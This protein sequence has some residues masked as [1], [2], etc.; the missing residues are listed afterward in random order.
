MTCKE[1]D[2]VFCTGNQAGGTYFVDLLQSSDKTFVVVKHY[3]DTAGVWI[4]SMP[5]ADYT[6]VKKMK[7]TSY[8]SRSAYDHAAVCP[9]LSTLC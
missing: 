8:S 7:K 5:H 4:L 9:Y 3:E 6:I 2:C 1:Y